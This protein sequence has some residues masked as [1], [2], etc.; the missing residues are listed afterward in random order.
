MKEKARTMEMVFILDKSGSM[1]GLEDDTIGGFN[2]MIERQKGL[3]GDASVTTVLFDTEARR[4]HDGISIRDIKPLTRRDYEPGGCTA[5][6][7][8]VGMTVSAVYGRQECMEARPLHTIVVIITDGAENSSKEYSYGS[9]QR[10]IQKMRKSFGWE[11][12]FL[13]ANIDAAETASSIGIPR[14]RAV[15]Y[16][17]DR[18]GTRVNFEAVGSALC[19]LRENGEVADGWRD[20]VDS[21]FESR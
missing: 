10:M 16:H 14:K 19:S 5:L 1:S 11:F 20:A 6:L 13:G 2:S 17:A 18:K 4:I 9:V 3:C 15:N 12:I 7:D 21:D 8:A